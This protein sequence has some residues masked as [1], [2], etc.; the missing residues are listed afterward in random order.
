MVVV[1]VFVDV[2]AIRRLAGG[3]GPAAASDVDAASETTTPG[4]S[5]PLGPTAVGRGHTPLAAW[6]DLLLRRSSSSRSSSIRPSRDDGDG[7]VGKPIRSAQA[8][9]RF[10]SASA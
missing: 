4:A 9:L 10:S 8:D 6:T 7:A 5:P 2:F 1:V 3:A